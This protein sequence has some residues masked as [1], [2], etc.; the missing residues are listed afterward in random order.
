M[1][2]KTYDNYRELLEAEEVQ[3]QAVF[4]MSLI[5]PQNYNPECIDKY[6]S[7][8][9]RYHNVSAKINLS[10]AL[11]PN[12][13]NEQDQVKYFSNAEKCLNEFNENLKYISN[14][15]RRL[16][17]SEVLDYTKA[18]LNYKKSLNEIGTGRKVYI[19]S[20]LNDINNS[21][22]KSLESLVDFKI[23]E[24]ILKIDDL[25]DCLTN[26]NEQEYYKIRV[27][28]TLNN[29]SVC[30][31]LMS[32]INAHIATLELKCIIMFLIMYYNYKN[33]IS[34]DS[35]KDTVEKTKK[36]INFTYTSLVDDLMRQR[37]ML[38]LKIEFERLIQGASENINLIFN[39][40]FRSL[41]IDDNRF[42]LMKNIV[43]FLSRKFD[44]LNRNEINE[45]C[46]CYGIDKKLFN[47][48]INGHEETLEKILY[49]Y[50]TM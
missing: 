27:K 17:R 48:D 42:K 29:A 37:E 5:E 47:I 10:L 39:D 45:C 28:L 4:F 30:K 36:I 22:K 40:R 34:F 6:Y 38:L 7:S 33:G 26:Y 24:E 25:I 15:S 21:E 46:L 12:F 1:L 31:K 3:K 32:D 35:F 23:S 20:A 44:D 43:L 11:F 14:N 8:M 49:K 19:D 18:L 9:S 50:L 16:C 41:D 2:V 13:D